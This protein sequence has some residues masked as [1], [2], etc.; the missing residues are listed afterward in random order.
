MPEFDVG[1]AIKDS[2]KSKLRTVS[3]YLEEVK[4]KKWSMKTRSVVL[5]ENQDSYD[6]FE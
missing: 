5:C 2:V 3:E 4:K 1:K 6:E